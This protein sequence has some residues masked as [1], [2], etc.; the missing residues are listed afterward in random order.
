MTNE[1]KDVAECV[2]DSAIAGHAMHCLL[3]L[4]QHAVANVPTTLLCGVLYALLLLTETPVCVR[5]V[6][7]TRITRLQAVIAATRKHVMILFLCLV[8]TKRAMA[9]LW[10]VMP[11]CSFTEKAPFAVMLAGVARALSAFIV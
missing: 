2:T 10:Y 11:A 9:V 1:K 3:I 4:K 6:S 7:R 5:H 8:G